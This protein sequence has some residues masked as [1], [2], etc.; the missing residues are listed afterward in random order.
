MGNIDE[1]YSA[2]T[3]MRARASLGSRAVHPRVVSRFS[4]KP[5]GTVQKLTALARSR[6]DRG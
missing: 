3:S 1:L 6:D 5:A 2:P 4:A